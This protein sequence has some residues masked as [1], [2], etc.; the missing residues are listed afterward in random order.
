MYLSRN[1]RARVTR[2]CKKNQLNQNVLYFKVAE[3]E[4]FT[5]TPPLPTTA[6]KRKGMDIGILIDSSS[7]VTA[8]E[9][10][11][12]KSFILQLVNTINKKFSNVHFGIIAYSDKPDL[13]MLL[14]NLDRIKVKSIIEDVKYNAGG[15]RTDLAMLLAS[16]KLFCPKGCDDRP[17][18]ENVLIVFTSG[19]TD[20]GS[21]EYNLVSPIMKVSKSTCLT[22]NTIQNGSDTL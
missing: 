9:F 3:A 5:L 1:K 15:H 8:D 7:G 12:L 10:K 11:R 17:E 16:Q 20:A 6:V 18:V 4:S 19:K 13:V 22:N 14:Q 21:L 2:F